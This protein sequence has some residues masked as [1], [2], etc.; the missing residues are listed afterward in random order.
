M[1]DDIQLVENQFLIHDN[2]TYRESVLKRLNKTF[3]R[4]ISFGNK[5]S[6]DDLSEHGVNL[7]PVVF[8]ENENLLK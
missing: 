6:I 2:A 1:L 7:S 3:N 8:L 4:R 5:K